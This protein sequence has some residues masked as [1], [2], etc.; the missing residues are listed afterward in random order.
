VI[1][2]NERERL[3]RCLSSVTVDEIVVVDSDSDDG[4]PDV[5]R[6]FGANLLQPD[7]WPG[8]GPQKNRALDAATGDWVLSLDADEWVEPDLMRIILATIADPEAA[9]CYYL[10]RRSRFCG[11]VVRHSGWWPDHVLR[12]FRRGKA[13]FSD[14]RVHERV[15]AGGTVGTLSEPIQHEAIVSRDDA[16]RKAARYGRAAAERLAE[17]GRRGGRAIAATRAGWT[18]VRLFLFRGGFLDGRTGVGVAA[19]Q[20]SQ[21]WQ[22]WAGLYR[23][24]QERQPMTGDDTGQG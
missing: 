14:D 5:A 20:A 21:T 4:T 12:L 24:G 2:R 13:R 19:Y 16:R 17:E 9:D 11:K 3:A 22:K 10:P 7:D 1:V 8:F 18:F 15:I 6:R 23:L